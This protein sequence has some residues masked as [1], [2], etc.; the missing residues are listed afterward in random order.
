MDPKNVR[1]IL[2]KVRLLQNDLFGDVKRSKN[3]DPKFRLRVGDDR[4]LFNVIGQTIQVYR[5]IHRREA[6]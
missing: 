4:V 3:F 6:Y 5:I 1:Q 2:G